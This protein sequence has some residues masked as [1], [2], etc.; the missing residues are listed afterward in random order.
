MLQNNDTKFKERIFQFK[1]K[2]SYNEFLLLFFFRKSIK[3]TSNQQWEFLLEQCKKSWRSNLHE[4]VLTKILDFL[5]GEEHYNT[6][7]HFKMKKKL[8]TKENGIFQKLGWSKFQWCK[9]SP[10]NNN[11]NSTRDPK[12]DQNP[13][14]VCRFRWRLK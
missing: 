7:G 4:K 3:V 8:Q 6:K 12:W 10:N 13:L 14:W 9:S 5:W 1:H 11:N 2:L